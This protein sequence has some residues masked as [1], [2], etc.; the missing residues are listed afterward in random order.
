MLYNSDDGLNYECKGIILDHQNKDMLLFEGKID[1]QYYALTRPLGECYFAVLSRGPSSPR[2]GR[3][4]G[5]YDLLFKRM[6]S[7]KGQRCFHPLLISVV[8]AFRR[9]ARLRGGSAVP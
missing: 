6:V 2:G 9:G 4:A 3:N 8:Y 5:T 1:E 7:M